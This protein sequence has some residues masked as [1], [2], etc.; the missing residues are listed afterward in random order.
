[1]FF[2]RN[3]L[4]HREFL[5]RNQDGNVLDIQWN[6]SSD[7]LAILLENSSSEYY[8]QLWSRSNYQW[9]LKKNLVFGKKVVRMRWQPEKTMSLFLIL[10][11]KLH[12][13]KFVGFILLNRWVVLQ[14]FILLGLFSE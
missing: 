6:P 11:G 3:G 1:M 14:I 8:V 12:D 10:E 9:Y 4:R 2:E 7:L 13:S 5:L